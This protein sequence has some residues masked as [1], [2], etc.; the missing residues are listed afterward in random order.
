VA[1]QV[2]LADVGSGQYNPTNIVADLNLA[3]VKEAHGGAAV[4]IAGLVDTYE[5]AWT[6]A[7]LNGNTN[8]AAVLKPVATAIANG[9]AEGSQ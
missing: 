2:I 5:K 4:T 9:L 8:L 1:S 6:Q 3:S 7:A